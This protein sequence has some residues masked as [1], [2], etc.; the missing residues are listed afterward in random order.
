MAV[1]RD[2]P[3][4]DS[5]ARELHAPEATPWRAVSLSPQSFVNIDITRIGVILLPWSGR[6]RPRAASA[7]VRR[8]VRLRWCGSW[9]RASRTP[10]PSRSRRTPE[11]RCG[12]SIAT[13]PPSTICC[14]PTTP[15]CT[16]FARRWTDRPATESI[17]DSVQAA[18]F[19]FPYDVDAVAKI[20]ALRDDEIDPAASSGISRTCKPTSPMPSQAQ[21][22]RRSCAVDPTPDDRVRVAV[23]ARCIAAAVFGAMEVWMLGD[24]SV[25]WRAGAGL[26]CGA[27]VAARRH[28]RGLGGPSFVI[29]DKTFG[30]CQPAL[31]EGRT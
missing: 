16:G 15:D 11:S 30:P 26:P 13:S 12:R 10:R 1:R 9:P 22:Q 5:E 23:T 20:A 18:I 8:C 14:S 6:L 25:A 17:I 27:G 2:D 28:H 31:L 21:L 19:A 24:G 3:A 7:L 29:I 4:D